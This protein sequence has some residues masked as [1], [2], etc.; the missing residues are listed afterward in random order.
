[1]GVL[2]ET[3]GANHPQG[4]GAG[5]KAAAS[6]LVRLLYPHWPRPCE[7]EHSTQD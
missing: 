3:C 5:I 1:V 2:R 4:F 7:L 6:P